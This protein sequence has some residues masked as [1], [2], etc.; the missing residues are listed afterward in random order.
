[1]NEPYRWG[2]ASSYRLK[3]FKIFLLFLICSCSRMTTE[4]SKLSQIPEGDRARIEK[5]LSYLVW[6][7]TFAYVLFGNKP[8]SVCNQDK[9]RSPY[10][11]EIDPSPVYELES[12]WET[13]KKYAHLFPMNEFL[14]LTEGNEKY[15]EVYLLNKSNC[16]KAIE[17][18]LVLFQERT[19]CNLNAF[20]MFDYIVTHAGN[21]LYKNS[22]SKSQGLYG[23]LL[24]F[25][26]ENSFG[27][28]NYYSVKREPSLNST[29]HIDTQDPVLPPIPFFASFS[30]EE[31]KKLIA[32]YQQQRRKILKIYSNKDFLETTIN[33]LT[34]QR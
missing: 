20:E 11:L 6:D 2:V 24:G 10:Y 25:G 1:M 19:G 33:Q 17:N 18:N 12:L 21:D 31:T 27:F 23:I 15:F 29:A 3:L 32:D 4:V 28:E 5:L 30:A 8:M 14:F 22:L 16:L 7:E 13:W 9:I 34:K 26:A